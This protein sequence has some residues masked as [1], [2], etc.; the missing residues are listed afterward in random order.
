MIDVQN[1]S[2]VLAAH[3]RRPESSL[4]CISAGSVPLVPPKPQPSHPDAATELP[5]TIA[6][7]L[8][9]VVMPTAF[10]CAV[11]VGVR[12]LLGWETSSVAV[13]CVALVIAGFLLIIRASLAMDH[14]A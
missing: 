1:K 2:M 14:T 13:S 3:F 4:P 8:L 5:H 9:I 11:L 6:S 7:L 12:S 10:W